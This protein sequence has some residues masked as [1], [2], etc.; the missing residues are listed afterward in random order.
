MTLLLLLLLTEMRRQLGESA[1]EQRRRLESRLARRRQLISE[2]AAAGLAVDDATVDEILGHEDDA[3]TAK[4]RVRRRGRS[5]FVVHRSF[6]H[7]P[8][9]GP[10]FHLTPICQLI[11]SQTFLEI[12]GLLD[13]MS[14][15]KM[16]LIYRFTSFFL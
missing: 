9:W 16:L 10:S 11:L 4:R 6:G 2:R 5:L 8:S 3:P 14:Q 1:S 13:S 12:D 15:Y 7:Q